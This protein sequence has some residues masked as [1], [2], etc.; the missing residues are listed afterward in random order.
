L[1]STF[2]NILGSNSSG[3]GFELLNPTEKY[4]DPIDELAAGVT[5]Y[6]SNKEQIIN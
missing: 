5:Y 4:K 1:D 2:F 3:F 6:E